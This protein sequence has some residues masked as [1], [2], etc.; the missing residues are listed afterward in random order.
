[1]I[2]PGGDYKIF[3]N[4][5]CFYVRTDC[6]ELPFSNKKSVKIPLT[7]SEYLTVVNTKVVPDGFYSEVKVF[8]GVHQTPEVSEVVLYRPGHLQKSVTQEEYFASTSA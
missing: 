7:N 4:G 3:I 1:M 8:S 5:V 2:Y 6:L